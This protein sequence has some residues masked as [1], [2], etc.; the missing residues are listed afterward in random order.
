[1]TI[2]LRT[3]QGWEDLKRVLD[4]RPHDVLDLCR[5]KVKVK[6]GATIVV[7]DPRGDGRGNFAIWIKADG[8]SWKSFTDDS[9]RGRALEL[10]A[11]CHGWYHLDRRGAAEAANFAMSRLG[12]AG[13]SQAQLDADRAKA[14]ERQADNR[15]QIDAEADRRRKAAF[16]IFA[17]AKPLLGTIGETYCRVRRGIDLRQDPFIGPRG[18]SW[19]PGSL[20]FIVR[21]KYIIRD[22]SGDACGRF[23]APAIVACCTDDEGKICAV[24]QT[25]LAPDGHDKARIPPAP[26]GTAQKARRVLGDSAGLVIPL[27]RGDGHLSVREAAE[28]GLLQTLG[29]TEGWEDGMSMVLAS[30]QH[31]VWA[32]IS[33]SNMVNVAR[34]LPGCADSVIVHR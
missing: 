13:I 22:R 10:I 33:L 30:P 12:I 20:R 32:M 28:N 23:Y 18:G 5:I 9:K 17:E 15:A 6:K 11:Y 29:L 16:A 27:W 31:R 1:M 21:H 19:A 3:R 25:W 26:D 24:H 4:D 7:D 34:R 14:Q 8:L 2:N